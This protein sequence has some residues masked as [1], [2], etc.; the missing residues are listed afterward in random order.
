M[1]TF[2]ENKINSDIQ[3]IAEKDLSGDISVSISSL[4]LFAVDVREYIKGIVSQSLETSYRQ[5]L[6]GVSPEKRSHFLDLD[7][8]YLA[9]MNEWIN[10]EEFTIPAI[11]FIVS[12]KEDEMV[13]SRKSLRDLAR[14]RSNQVTA[15]ASVIAIVL[16][17]CGAKITAF[18]VAEVLAVGLCV[19]NNSLQNK[20]SSEKEEKRRILLQQSVNDYIASIENEAFDWIR[21]AN[22]Y[23]ESLIKQL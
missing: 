4:R 14:V 23:S 10:T 9:K 12:N 6:D 16:C 18:I 3:R 19:Y 13:T 11:D 21:R 20:L 8:G 7:T 22:S 1:I 5:E 2:D 17:C 15:G